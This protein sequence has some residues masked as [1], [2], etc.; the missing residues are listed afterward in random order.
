MQ[1][2]SPSNKAKSELDADPTIR[3]NVGVA[4]SLK[5]EIKKR[6]L[7]EDLSVNALCVKMFKEYLKKHK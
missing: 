6:A 3:L 4:Y 1:Q 7:D 2:T 5:K